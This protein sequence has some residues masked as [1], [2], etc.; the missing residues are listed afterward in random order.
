MSVVVGVVDLGFVCGG[1]GAAAAAVVVVVVVVVRYVTFT[2]AFVIIF[3][4]KRSKD[5]IKNTT[6]R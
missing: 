4:T 2:A 6:C 1:C 3:L 5:R